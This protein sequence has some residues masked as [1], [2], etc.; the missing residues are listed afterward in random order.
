MNLNGRTF[1]DSVF[2]VED[3][4]NLKFSSDTEVIAAADLV[5]RTIFR[6]FLSGLPKLEQRAKKRIELSGECAEGIPSLVTVVCFLPG[7]AKDLSA[8]PHTSSFLSEYFSA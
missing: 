5:G 6:I 2:L 7:R 4:K 8:P 1:H 3:P